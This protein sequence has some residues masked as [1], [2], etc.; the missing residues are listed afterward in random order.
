VGL[1]ILKNIIQCEKKKQKGERK[2]KEV[3]EKNTKVEET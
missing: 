1:D 3:G 2:L